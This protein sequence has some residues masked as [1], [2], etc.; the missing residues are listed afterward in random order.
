M[1]LVGILSGVM[2]LTRAQLKLLRQSDPDDRLRMALHLSRAR[3]VELSKAIGIVQSQVSQDING[4]FSEM[5]LHKA[6]AYARFFG[7]S[8]EDLFPA[9]VGEQVA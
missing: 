3:Q 4:Q 6:A 5:S 7:C 2:K 8:L 9:V 1:A